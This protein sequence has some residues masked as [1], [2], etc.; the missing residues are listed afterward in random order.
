MIP[1][2]RLC[3]GMLMC[4]NIHRSQQCSEN[5]EPLFCNEILES[6]SKSRVKMT[7]PGFERL[8]QQ[9]RVPTGTRALLGLFHGKYVCISGGI[10]ERASCDR[11]KIENL[12]S[13]MNSQRMIRI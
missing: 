13:E 6:K 1:K 5:V 7:R 4:K 8:A 3:Y 2:V 11:Q 9:L 12:S 10:P